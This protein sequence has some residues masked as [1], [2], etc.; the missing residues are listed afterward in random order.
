MLAT[1]FALA[2][3]AGAAPS[4]ASACDTLAAFQAPGVRIET[5][6]FQ[7]AGPLAMKGRPGAAATPIELP[8]HCL[9][10][11]VIDKRIGVGGRVYGIHF[12][13][14][15]P[16]TWNHRFLF[17]GGGG[18]NG[19]VAP[20]IGLVKGPPALT[21]G[22]A[23]VTQDAGHAGGDGSFGEDQQAR[24]DMAFRSYDR[25]TAVAKQLVGAFYGQPAD[26]SYFM[27][28]SEGGREALLVSQ[29]QPLDFDGVVA[30]DPGFLLGVEFHTTTE[31]MLVAELAQDASGAALSGSG[32][33]FSDPDIALVETAI[34]D[35]CDALDGLKDGIIDNPTACRPRLD[36]LICKDDKADGCLTKTQVAIVRAI[37]EGGRPTGADLLS[38]GYFYD[39]GVDTFLWTS[40][41]NGAG[42]QPPGVSS[43]G[44]F[45][46][47]PYDP[48]LN[49]RSIDFL[50]G[51]ADRFEEVGSL[52][53]T[54]GV[55]YA[56]F[57]QHGGKLLIYTGQ[58]DPAFS[59]KTLL[60]YYNR[61]AAN[62]GGAA[63]TAD[64]A[65]VF[66]VPGMT[67]CGGGKS[68]DQ[69]DPLQAVVDW[70]EK[71]SAPVALVTTGSAFPGRSRP[72]CAWPLQSRY[73][74]AG[75]TEDAANFSC[76]APE[77]GAPRSG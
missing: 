63:A 60:N 43:E 42:F 4:S 34:E 37:Y 76:R 35:D 48:S 22:F 15:L 67:H 20:A 31:R 70:V 18:T 54:D 27:G 33:L 9:V 10:A 1:V 7:R 8:A 13:L 41:L 23:V 62:N 11:G 69:F 3:S 75:S 30:G 46:S 58:S 14:R 19:V 65:R 26:H 55:M 12:E 51:G 77:V 32:K 50:H 2:T 74:G 56:S 39:T 59:A 73:K 21:K 25:V 17:E 57:K 72:V 28:C 5:S 71:G 45:F 29:R 38:K 49:T 64:F 52:N 68:L 66:I 47:T 61:L 6:S 36:R 40:K 44:G 16:T 53:R 24:I